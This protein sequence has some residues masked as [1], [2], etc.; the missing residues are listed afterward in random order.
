MKI[1]FL[2][3]SDND[4]DND[5]DDDDDDDKIKLFCHRNSDSLQINSEFGRSSVGFV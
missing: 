3:S 4:D 2:P 1:V 5:D